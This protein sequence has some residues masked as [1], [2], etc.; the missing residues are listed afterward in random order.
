MVMVLCNMIIKLKIYL[1]DNL[2]M[3]KKLEKELQKVINFN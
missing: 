1:Q 3:V 2:L